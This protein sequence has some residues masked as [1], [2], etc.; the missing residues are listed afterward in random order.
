MGMFLEPLRKKLAT[1]P[2]PG[3][4]KRYGPFIL[5][6][7]EIEQLE[8]LPKRRVSQILMDWDDGPHRDWPFNTFYAILTGSQ[9]TINRH[10]AKLGDDDME[11]VRTTILGERLLK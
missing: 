3:K 5:S 11:R 10:V 2:D 6:L 9:P 7:M 4:A 8:T 1:L